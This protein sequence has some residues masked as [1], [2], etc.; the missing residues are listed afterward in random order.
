MA[1]Q[2]FICNSACSEL[3]WEPFWP[4]TFRLGRR[5]AASF[6][7]HHTLGKSVQQFEM[8]KILKAPTNQRASVVNIYRYL[9]KKKLSQYGESSVV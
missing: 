1:K 7:N 9:C 5:G 2:S 4:D 8:V 6:L 3:L